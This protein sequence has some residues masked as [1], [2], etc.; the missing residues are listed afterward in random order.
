MRALIWITEG[1][2]AACVDR[3][4]ELLPADAEIT[5][6]HVAAADAEALA[7]HPAPG[8]LGRHRPPPP[9][10]TVREVSDEEA[11][12]LLAQAERR[13][14]RPAATIARRGRAEREVLEAA[15]AA[16][17]LVLARGGEP[18]REPKSVG[19]EA[20]FVLDHVGCEVLIVWSERPPGLESM[21][22]PPHLRDR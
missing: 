16:D 14:D 11:A 3:A 19:R 20:R 13:L 7:E 22:W 1:S 21:R 12:A 2:W 18:R 4:R 5:L 15:E 9:G 17:L 10:P 6:L 8:R